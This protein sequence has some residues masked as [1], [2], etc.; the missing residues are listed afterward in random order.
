MAR[1]LL[2]V[3][4]PA[5]LPELA[6][7]LRAWRAAGIEVR[8]CSLAG[9]HLD[10]DGVDGVAAGGADHLGAAQGV[11]PD[12]AALVRDTEGLDAALLIG[13]PRRAPATVLPAP[14]ALDAHG[15]RVVLAWLPATS[16]LALRRFA[17]TAA[18]VHRRAG[19]ERGL[20]LFG[21]WHPQYLRVVDRMGDLLAS[22]WRTFKWTGDQLSR[23][24]LVGAMGSGV[25][26]GVYLGHGRPVGWVG[27]HG[28]RSHHFDA[29]EGEPMGAL[30]SLCCR[31]AS[32]RRTGLSY[33]EALP[34]RGVAAASFGAISDTLHTD[35]TRWA[36]G[37]CDA[38]AEGVGT[39]GELILRAAPASPGAITPY[40]LMGD[41]FAPLSTQEH[42]LARA[43]AVQVYP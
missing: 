24:G 17:A 42:D 18:R 8:H 34:L 39:V 43:G 12:M 4:A 22:H 21:Q 37:L 30:M 3:C 25:G 6:V 32:R 31:T 28:V 35:N 11:L 15:R 23:E 5:R 33:A 29:F 36:V 27:Y 13:S 14:F 2:L 16:A 40:R 10:A 20:A 9:D 7:L 38:L 41:P 26:L 19:T 1:R